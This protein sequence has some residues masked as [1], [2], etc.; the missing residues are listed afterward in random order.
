[1][2]HDGVAPMDFLQKVGKLI[3]Q[4]DKGPLGDTPTLKSTSG[5]GLSFSLHLAYD[6]LN[7]EY[8]KGSNLKTSMGYG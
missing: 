3:K 6:F 4:K 7:Y 8:L 1:M 5:R 2:R